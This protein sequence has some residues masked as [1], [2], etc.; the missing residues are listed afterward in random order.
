MLRRLRDAGMAMIYVSHRLDEV[1]AIADRAVVLRDGFLVCDEPIAA[2]DGNRLIELIVGRALDEVF[3]RPEAQAGAP[4]ALRLEGFCSEDV[5]PVDL[6]LREGEIVGLVGLRGAGQDVVGRALFGRVPITAG[7][8]LLGDGCALATAHPTDSIRQGICM[9]AG[10][11]NAESVAAGLTVMENLTLNP[12]LKGR[13]L[14][15]LGRPAREETSARATGR[16]F[17]IRPNDPSAPIETLS[18]GNQ[19]KVVMARWLGVGVRVLILDDPTAGVDVGAKADIY[20]LLNRA[21]AEGLAVLLAST[22]FEEVAAL[23]HRALVFHEGRVVAELARGNL[24]MEAL[25][26]AASLGTAGA[27]HVAED[28]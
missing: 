11:R 5:G 18:G 7:G 14:F 24:S 20:A 16:V 1:F 22:D 8:A 15:T 27:K 12:G 25:L 19:Q 23:C 21:L 3:V 13:G 10:D 9:V 28:A 4:V 26:N 2:L 6:A 17:D